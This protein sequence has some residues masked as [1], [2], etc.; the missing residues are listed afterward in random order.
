MAHPSLSKDQKKDQKGSKGSKDQKLGVIFLS[1]KMG[2][3]LWAG[4][5]GQVV[6][7]GLPLPGVALWAEQPLSITLCGQKYGQNLPA[8]ATLTRVWQDILPTTEELICSW[9][10]SSRYS[11]LHVK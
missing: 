4:V 1:Q 10:V 11:P 9:C 7:E 8:H 3:C 5:G 6:T 2:T